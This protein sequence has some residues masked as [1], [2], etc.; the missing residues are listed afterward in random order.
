MH[1]VLTSAA[2]SNP[3]TQILCQRLAPDHLDFAHTNSFLSDF[4]KSSWLPPYST[5]TFPMPRVWSKDHSYILPPSQASGSRML[6]LVHCPCSKSL[7]N[8][9][10]SL[11]FV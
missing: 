1:S 5:F 6:E 8:S 3:Y 2:I 10:M 7:T 11:P 4:S 9:V